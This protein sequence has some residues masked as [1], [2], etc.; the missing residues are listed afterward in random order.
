MTPSETVTCLALESLTNLV[1][2]D[3]RLRPLS[4]TRSAACAFFRGRRGGLVLVNLCAG[5]GEGF[6]VQ[7]VTGDVAGDVG[8]HGE[9]GEHGLLC[10][11]CS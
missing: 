1:N 6:N 11:C 3:S 4:S 10:R 5:F 8:E 9:G 7:V 2:Q